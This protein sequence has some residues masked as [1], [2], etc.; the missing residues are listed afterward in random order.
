MR[1]KNTRLVDVHATKLASAFREPAYGAVNAIWPIVGVEGESGRYPKFGVGAVIP[2]R[3]NFIYT[4][5]K[6]RE[7]LDVTMSGG[8]FANDE[9]SLEIPMYDV[10]MRNV[11]EANRQRFRDGKVRTVAGQ[12][13]LM[14]E[15]AVAKMLKDSTKYDANFTA[16]LAGNDRWTDVVNSN[17]Y[18]ALRGWIFLVASQ[19]GCTTQEIGV[20]FDPKSMRALMDHPKTDTKLGNIG[21]EFSYG[22]LQAQLEVGEITPLFGQ[23]AT[24]QSA[25]DPKYVYIFDDVVIVYKIRKDA[26]YGDPLWGAVT[27]LEGQP[28]VTEYRDEPRRADI[29]AQDDN[30]GIVHNTNKGGFLARTVTG[31]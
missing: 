12:H 18:K 9:I 17:P 24:S 7:R 19:L 29:F 6:E 2:D 5:G 13:L 15:Y 20:A 23:Y 27:R 3:E 4:L 31:L 8:R 30:W 16:A 14:M 22:W 21:K 25:D 11:P 26:A 1:V 10:E 28:L